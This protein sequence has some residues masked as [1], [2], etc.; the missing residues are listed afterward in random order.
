MSLGRASRGS[1]GRRMRENQRQRDGRRR[2]PVGGRSSRGCGRKLKLSSPSKDGRRDLGEWAN[3]PRRMRDLKG[4]NIGALVDGKR[5]TKSHVVPLGNVSRRRVK[6][7][8]NVVLV[9]RKEVLG[10]ERNAAAGAGGGA[11][12]RGTEE[13][14]NARGGGGSPRGSIMM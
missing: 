3:N 13:G 5:V 7:P 8:I 2:R 10:P 9:A 4:C 6:I 1:P 12:A 14:K 11:F